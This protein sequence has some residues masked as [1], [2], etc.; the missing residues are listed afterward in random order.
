MV[1]AWPG[2]SVM[3]HARRACLISHDVNY[4]QSDCCMACSSHFQI[5]FLLYTRANTN[6]PQIVS[7]IP[8]SIQ[9][10]HFSGA[11]KTKFIIHGYQDDGHGPWLITM[12][13]AILTRVMSR[14]QEHRL[15]AFT[16]LKGNI[17]R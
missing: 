13:H 6:A 15:C 11:K 7:K 5:K 16:G 8:L 12:A 10:S 4:C 3:L 14:P 17:Q 9:Q 2:N 1:I